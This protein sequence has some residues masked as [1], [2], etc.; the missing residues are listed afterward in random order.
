MKDGVIKNDGTSRFIKANLPATYEEMRVMAAAGTL[1][2]DVLFN[3]AGWDILPDFLNKENLLKDKTA[4]KLGLGVDAVPDDIL[5]FVIAPQII[6]AAEG[7]ISATCT[8]GDISLTAAFLDGI[9]VFNVPEYGDYTIVADYGNGRTNTGTVRVDQVAQY[10]LDFGKYRLYLYDTGDQCEEV[11]GGWEQNTAANMWGYAASGGYVNFAAD[12][13]Y[14]NA[15]DNISAVANSK[16]K[17]TIS[18]LSKMVA[19]FGTVKD[20]DPK[21][22]LVPD[23]TGNLI[24]ATVK[25]LSPAGSNSTVEVSISDVSGSYYIAFG[26]ASGRN[27]YLKQLWME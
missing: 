8:K 22:M 4:E 24:T 27:A 2:M 25:S 18:G 26:T 23:K 21:V 9:C 3:A 13:I 14:I 6:V 20:N 16:N 10:P 17:I 1:P 7:G 11:T 15:P 12:S 5:K 19:V